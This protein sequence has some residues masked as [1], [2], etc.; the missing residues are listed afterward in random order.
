M[1]KRR[2]EIEKKQTN[3]SKTAHTFFR[4]FRFHVGCRL[5][6]LWEVGKHIYA[7][8]L[9]AHIHLTTVGLFFANSIWC[10]CCCRCRSYSPFINVRKQ[11][12]H[13]VERILTQISIQKLNSNARKCT[14][15][16]QTVSSYFPKTNKCKW[17]IEIHKI[18]RNGIDNERGKIGKY[19]HHRYNQRTMR[20]NENKKKTKK[21]KIKKK[22]P[23][24]K[25]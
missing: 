21:R 3:F 6:C 11:Y 20:N 17:K 18:Q 15:G 22:I 25:K 24:D 13:N 4:G 8:V 14:F 16:H 10:S 7:H 12:M 2:K 19:E 9:S 23:V 5:K 1:E